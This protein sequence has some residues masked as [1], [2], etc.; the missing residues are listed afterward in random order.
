[1]TTECVGTLTFCILIK[2]VT[3]IIAMAI[4]IVGG[5]ALLAFFIGIARFVFAAG[6][7][8]AHKSG[9]QLMIWGLVALFV[10][11]SVWG[12]IRLLARTIGLS[13]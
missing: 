10:M 13:V 4:P 1:M 8:E 7:S 12:I 11:F 9:K 2:K 5:L 3:A 6:D